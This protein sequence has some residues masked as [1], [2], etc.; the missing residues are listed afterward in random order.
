[1]SRR[2][3]LRDEIAERHD[4]ANPRDVR[5]CNYTSIGFGPIGPEGSRVQIEIENYYIITDRASN[6]MRDLE[7]WLV[8]TQLD[9]Y[10][11]YGT[12]EQ[13]A[14]AIQV[15]IRREDLIKMATE[16]LRVADRR[17]HEWPEEP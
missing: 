13:P 7:N 9:E 8:V 17:E 3:E 1:M 4:V 6:T 16:F 14:P 2:R 5:E 10:D 15:R 12:I 11:D